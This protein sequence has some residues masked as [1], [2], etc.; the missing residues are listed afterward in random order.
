VWGGELNIIL[1]NKGFAKLVT[2]GF[3][4]FNYGPCFKSYMLDMYDKR[5]KST[6]AAD[7]N[8]WKLMMNNLYGKMGQQLHPKTEYVDQEVQAYR[9]ITETADTGKITSVREMGE[10]IY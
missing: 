2:T 6:T 1:A 9:L 8:F 3:H 4:N 7:K 10:G 5:K